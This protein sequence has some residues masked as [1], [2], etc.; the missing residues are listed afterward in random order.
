LKTL[1]LKNKIKTAAEGR[2][3]ILKNNDVFIEES[4]R[5][6]LF[7]FNKEGKLLWKYVSVHEDNQLYRLGWSRIIDDNESFDVINKLLKNSKCQR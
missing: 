5:G 6:R 7:Y 1:F 2:S 4:N 3:T